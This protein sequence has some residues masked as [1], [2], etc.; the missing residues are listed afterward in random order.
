MC[1][2]PQRKGEE[3]GEGEMVERKGGRKGR[4]TEGERWI[5][6]MQHA[7]R[8]GESTHRGEEGCVNQQHKRGD[9]KTKVTKE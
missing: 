2:I 3:E 5:S 1:F 8:L 6:H 4:G 9:S 7:Q